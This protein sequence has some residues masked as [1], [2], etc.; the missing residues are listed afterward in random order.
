MIKRKGAEMMMV[1]MLVAVCGWVAIVAFVIKPDFWAGVALS[2]CGGFAIGVAI[3]ALM[4]RWWLKRIPW[5]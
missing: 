1:I 4:I 2:L 5:Y 3:V